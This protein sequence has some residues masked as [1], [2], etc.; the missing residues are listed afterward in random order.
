MTG[1]AHGRL[2]MDAMRSGIFISLFH[3]SLQAS[4]ISS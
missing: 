1:R 4:R 2:V 3:A